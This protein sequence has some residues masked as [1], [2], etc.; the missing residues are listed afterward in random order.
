MDAS[1]EYLIAEAEK[2]LQDTLDELEVVMHD[3][4]YAKAEGNHIFLN[5]GMCV[6]GKKLN[7][8]MRIALATQWQ[9]MRS[10]GFG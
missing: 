8:V 9:P 7:F 10:F 4:Q 1:R 3:P 5:F 6:H 2:T